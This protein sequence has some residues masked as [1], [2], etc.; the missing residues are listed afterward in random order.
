MLPLHDICTSTRHLLTSPS[1]F[2]DSALLPA[3]RAAL[4]LLPR[5]PQTCLRLAYQQLHAVPYREVKACWRRLYVDAA[6]WVVVHIV[7]EAAGE[8]K[9]DEWISKVVEALD[10]AL[11]L[12]GAEG[13]EDVVGAWFE[14]LEGCVD[15]GAE[16]DAERPSKRRKVDDD[17]ELPLSFPT[18]MERT[19]KLKFPIPRS[20]EPSLS[21]FEAK[22]AHPETQTP[23]LIEGAIQHWPAFE[24]DRAWKNPHSLM[25]KTLGGRRL[26]PVEIGR[27]YTDAGWAQKILT[28]RAFMEE[29][30]LEHDSPP[31]PQPASPIGKKDE[32]SPP[33]PQ[34]KQKQK[35]YLAQH[36]LFAQIPS[37]R[38]DIAIPD[39]CYTSPAAAPSPTN[40]NPTNIPPAP[41][42][43]TPLLN[44]WFGPANTI[45]PLH[46]DPY[47][48]ILAQVV[49]YKYVRLYAPRETPRMYPRGVGGD[50]VD[51]GNT[52]CVDLEGAMGVWGEISCWGE[53]GGG[54]DGRENSGEEKDKQGIAALY[55]D[56]QTAR[57]VEGVLGP[58][59][60][61][62]V[63][64]GWW[65]YVRSLTP[66]FS[67]SFWWD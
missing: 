64:L 52:S 32:G 15:G 13:R 28:F 57:Y 54:A 66:S 1:P 63:P 18:T 30:M 45:S 37:L 62:Y 12:T 11:I 8:E 41:P 67:V 3:G 44:A 23:L 39:Y 20:R 33:T 22:V 65:H 17:D 40:L 43:D 48:N 7:E 16:N 51:M 34:K 9:G 49:G 2:E 56:F 61:L 6:L 31:S 38:A 59:E 58:G 53:G 50:G 35:G 10:M 47:H 26:V 4:S 55:P 42:L 24:A 29:Y 46:T 14:V 21:A 36:D 27:S 5:D 19:P 60:C 25:R